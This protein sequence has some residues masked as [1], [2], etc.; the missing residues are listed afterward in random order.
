MFDITKSQKSTSGVNGDCG[1]ED[2]EPVSHSAD[3]PCVT[4]WKQDVLM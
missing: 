2:L 1:V 3:I 4:P